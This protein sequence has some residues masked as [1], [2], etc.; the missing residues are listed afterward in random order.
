MLEDDKPLICGT[1]WAPIILDN[2]VLVSLKNTSDATGLS[3]VRFPTRIPAQDSLTVASCRIVIAS[4]AAPAIEMHTRLG[5][6]CDY[7]T[8]HSIVIVGNLQPVARTSF[9]DTVVG[10][11]LLSALPLKELA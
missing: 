10:T 8:G 3:V 2:T 9:K 5:T 7:V 1:Y 4:H 6:A 11:T